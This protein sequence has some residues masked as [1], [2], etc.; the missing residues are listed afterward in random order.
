M[1]LEL[2]RQFY[3]LIQKL[4]YHI[5]DSG[6]YKEL[7]PWLMLRTDGHQISQSFDT[8]TETVSFMLDV[9]STYSGEKEILEIIENINRNIVYLRETN[10]YIISA[11]QQSARIIDDNGTGPI[12]KHG[13]IRYTFLLTYSAKEEEDNDI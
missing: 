4:G 9:Y 7:F 2:K 8:T 13:V 1:V 11:N 5:T 3:E 12:R 6:E 10:P